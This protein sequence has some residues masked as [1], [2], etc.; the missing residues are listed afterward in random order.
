[1]STTPPNEP[2]EDFAGHLLSTVTVAA[3]E[4]HYSERLGKY[5]TAFP[6]ISC[7]LEELTNLMPCI[8]LLGVFAP[9]AYAMIWLMRIDEDHFAVSTALHA[10]VVAALRLIAGMADHVA[11]VR[12]FR[13][14]F[15]RFA[16]TLEC[17]LSQTLPR[18][19]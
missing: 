14:E 9:E 6:A 2:A 16:G 10:R 19:M 8:E 1:M 13:A 18:E 4:A 11:C 7:D 17:M 5:Y 15:I 3:V 12:P